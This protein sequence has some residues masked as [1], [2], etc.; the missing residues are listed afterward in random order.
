MDGT[1][2]SSL[3][4]GVK[5]APMEAGTPALALSIALM[6]L[7]FAHIL[8]L[9]AFSNMLIA[10]HSLSCDLLSERESVL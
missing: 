9:A 8:A 4:V 1:K 3:Q 5:P 7:P 2:V 6:A 10:G